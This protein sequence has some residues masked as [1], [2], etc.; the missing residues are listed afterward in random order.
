MVFFGYVEYIIVIV[1]VENSIGVFYLYGRFD[2]VSVVVEICW[3]LFILEI[4]VL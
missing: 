4:L 2:K 3:D 1:G